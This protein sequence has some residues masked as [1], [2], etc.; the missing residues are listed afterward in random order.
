M[1]VNT[2]NGRRILKV[3][4]RVWRARRTKKACQ[5]KPLGTA[6]VR[7]DGEEAAPRIQAERQPGIKIRAPNPRSFLAFEGE[8]LPGI[9]V[10]FDAWQVKLKKMIFQMD[11]ADRKSTRLNSS[12]RCIS[13]AVFCLKKKKKTNKK[14]THNHKKA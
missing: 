7:I 11:F 2:C 12:H 8:L 4:L 10:A 1:S 6:V 14:T 13:Y 3:L 9:T 5:R